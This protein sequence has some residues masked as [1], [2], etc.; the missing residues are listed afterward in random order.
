MATV[1]KIGPADHGRPMDLEEFLASDSEEGYHYELIDGELYVSPRANLP[2][3]VVEKWTYTKLDRYAQEHPEIINFVMFSA[4]VFVPGR[5][6]V[7]NPEPDVAAYRNFP[8]DRD[9][10]TLRWQDLSPVL[11]VEVLSVDDPD[12]DLVRNVDLYFQVPTIKE[13]WVIDTREDPNRPSMRVHRRH[14]RKWRIIHV[15]PGEIYTTKLLP[16]FQL[17]LD[18]RR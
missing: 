14:G 11:V 1:L 13:Y 12:K 5:R 4:R 2:Q 8:L 10:R 7:T 18:P 3:G 9:L 15:A 16:G 17:T 6:G